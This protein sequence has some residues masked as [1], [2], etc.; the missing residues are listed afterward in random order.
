[1]LSRYQ[2]A[3]LSDIVIAILADSRYENVLLEYQLVQ[4]ALEKK[5]LPVIR[6]DWS[7]NNFDWYSSQ[8][9]DLQKYL[10][11]SELEINRA[12]V[13]VSFSPKSD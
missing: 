12:R 2:L 3:V 4:S 7:K 10:G 8:V 9:C 13:M 5:E 11:L 1:M 6:V